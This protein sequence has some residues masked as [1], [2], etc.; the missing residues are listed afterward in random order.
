MSLFGIC[1]LYIITFI[2]FQLSKWNE[3]TKNLILIEEATGV[4]IESRKGK[5]LAGA[6]DLRKDVSSS[7]SIFYAIDKL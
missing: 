5:R 7:V 1:I 6:K 2:C 3:S 4:E